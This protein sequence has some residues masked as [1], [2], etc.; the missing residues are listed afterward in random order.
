MIRTTGHLPMVTLMNEGNPECGVIYVTSGAFH[1]AAAVSAAHS[2][3]ESNPWLAID[4]YTD[5]PDVDGPFDRIVAFSGGHRRSKVD[6]L[7]QTRFRRTLYLD[8][9]TM[10]VADLRPMFEL[11]SRFDLAI[12]HA[13]AR[14]AGRQTEIWRQEIPEAF[15]QHNGGVILYRGEGKTLK[16]MKDWS[17]AYHE[18]GFKWDQITLR[19]LMWMSDLAIYALPPEYNIR[20]RKYLDVW[21][22]REAVPKILH[23]EENYLNLEKLPGAPKRTDKGFNNAAARLKKWMLRW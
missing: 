1:T 18:A 15:P 22:E 20:Y 10:V 8:S 6:Y 23:L 11:L 12:A 14:N 2:V 9:A 13:H 5:E 16:F 19:E 21:T 17:T 3:R 7:A 4:L